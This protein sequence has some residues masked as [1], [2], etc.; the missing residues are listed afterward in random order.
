MVNRHMSEIKN[1]RIKADIEKKRTEQ[2]LK[3]IE[4]AALHPATKRFSYQ[5]ITVTPPKNPRQEYMKLFAAAAA[6]N[7]AN[8]QPYENY[9]YYANYPYYQQQYDP[10]MY[11]SVPSNVQT[12][13]SIED[14]SNK[15]ELSQ[16]SNEVLTPEQ[17]E[18]LPEYGSI[19]APWSVIESSNEK[20][21]ESEEEE[22]EEEDEEMIEGLEDKMAIGQSE[23]DEEDEQ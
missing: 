20:I 12:E 9:D 16:T 15:S 13:V 23:S 5:P 14:S 10:S 2:Q 8:N 1:K 7:A 4:R 6:L 21:E 11:N 17:K 3:D 19:Y 22:D 18:V